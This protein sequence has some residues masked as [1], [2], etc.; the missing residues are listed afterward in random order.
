MPK[1]L[2]NNL[3]LWPKCL[4]VRGMWM[5]TDIEQKAFTRPEPQETTQKHY[6]DLVSPQPLTSSHKQCQMWL[7]RALHLTLASQIEPGPPCD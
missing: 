6:R 1:C 3:K 7:S 4:I 2:M 5:T